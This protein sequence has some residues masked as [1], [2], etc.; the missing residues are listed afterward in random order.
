MP[1]SFLQ[2]LVEILKVETSVLL[3][4]ALK[5][6]QDSQ[7][8]PAN[9]ASPSTASQPVVLQTHTATA[10]SSHHSH[11]G[12]TPSQSGSIAANKT[13]YYP[14]H[15]GIAEANK[16]NDPDPAT[17][18]Q[19]HIAEASTSAGRQDDSSS[20]TQASNSDDPSR[21][22]QASQ[23]DAQLSNSQAVIQCRVAGVLPA[24]LAL[25]EGCLDSLAK[26]TE[27]AEMA[28]AGTAQPT[29]VLSNRYCTRIGQALNFVADHLAM[30]LCMR[31]WLMLC[32]MGYSP[33]QSLGVV[34]RSGRHLQRQ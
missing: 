25:L 28:E 10:T 23:P 9:S 8:S 4:D 2:I 7:G 29:V 17:A 14:D 24:V 18:G 3:N 32:F 34:E 11:P 16:T 31:H 6:L 13:A 30:L 1:G 5:L 27:N 19:A 26:E 15:G 33:P 22:P 20:N 12:D 21:Q